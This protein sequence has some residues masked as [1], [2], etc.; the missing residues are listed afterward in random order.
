MVIDWDGGILVCCEDWFRISKAANDFNINTHSIKEIWDSQFLND[1][2]KYLK[3]GK[4][5]KPVCNKCNM[6]GEKVGKE[7][8]KFYE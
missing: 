4:R 6:N 3:Q 7:F 2:R 1:Y 5:I 8:V